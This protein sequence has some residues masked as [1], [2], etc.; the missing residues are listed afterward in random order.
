MIKSEVSFL[1]IISAIGDNIQYF[2]TLFRT[3]DFTI[4]NY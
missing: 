3:A 1:H 4:I 2:F